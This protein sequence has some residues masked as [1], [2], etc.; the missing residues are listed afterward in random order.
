MMSIH[1]VRLGS[2]LVKEGA[3]SRQWS[4]LLHDHLLPS[5]SAGTHMQMSALGDCAGLE[6]ECTLGELLANACCGPLPEAA[7]RAV[8]ANVA[9]ALGELHADRLVHRALG[10]DAIVLG[11]GACFDTARC[12]LPP[13]L[14][15][16]LMG[17]GVRPCLDTGHSRRMRSSCG[18]A[19]ASTRS[20]ASRFLTQQLGILKTAYV[21]KRLRISPT[22][23]GTL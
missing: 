7:A 8:A 6:R 11:D 10:P 3:R 14:V 21:V 9:V 5:S 20:G 16:T 2:T 19:L 17:S 22:W 15:L 13:A 4:E 18:A 12:A 1:V 23:H